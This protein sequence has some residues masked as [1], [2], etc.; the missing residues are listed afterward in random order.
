MSYIG[1]WSESNPK[2]SLVDAQLYVASGFLPLS[3]SVHSRESESLAKS[4]LMFNIVYASG[5]AV[6]ESHGD[7]ERNRGD[8]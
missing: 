2:P 5:G 8:R 7:L 3:L 6:T 1:R 4:I